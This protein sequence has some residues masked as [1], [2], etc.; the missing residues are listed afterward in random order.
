MHSEPK[1]KR[2]KV[3]DPEK[4]VYPSLEGEVEDDTTHRRNM[5]LLTEE[6]EKSKPLLEKVKNLMKRTFMTRRE[7]ILN[8]SKS[9]REMVMEYPF[10]KKVPYVK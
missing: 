1:L 9:V 4:H 8:S 3:E 7:K 5:S 6:L 10:V 2:P